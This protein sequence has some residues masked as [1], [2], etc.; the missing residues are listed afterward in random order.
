MNVTK[1]QIVSKSIYFHDN[2]TN[3]PT[4]QFQKWLKL[5]SYN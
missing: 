3:I 4:I 5:F 1:K 2:T